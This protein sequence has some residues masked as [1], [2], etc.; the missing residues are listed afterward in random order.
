MKRFQAKIALSTALLI[1]TFLLGGCARERETPA[2]TPIS[3]GNNTMVNIVPTATLEGAN[4]TTVA[5]QN[6]ATPTPTAVPAGEIAPTNTPVPAISSESINATATP[7]TSFANTTD[8]STESGIHIVQAG[9]NL[10]RISLRYDV[11]MQ[12]LSRLNGITNPDQIYVGQRLKIPGLVSDG[13]GSEAGV[14]IVQPGDTMITIALRYNT[15]VSALMMAN[16]MNNPDFIYVG[17]RLTIP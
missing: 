5:I 13:G 16:N 17:Q 7:I 1:F 4:P 8:T 15:S 10:Y 9:E 14:H 3:S 6:T 2:A 12:E 11:S